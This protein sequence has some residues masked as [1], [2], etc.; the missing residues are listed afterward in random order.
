MS[1]NTIN[2]ICNIEKSTRDIINNFDQYFYI[3]KGF[4]KLNEKPNLTLDEQ[5]SLRMPKDNNSIIIKPADKGGATVILDK[6]N[7]ILEAIRQLNDTK[8]YK[9]NR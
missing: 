7:Y 5:N 9:K 8:Y 2:T 3:D 6:D 4:I 1:E